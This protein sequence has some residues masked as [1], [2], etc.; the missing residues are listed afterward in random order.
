MTLRWQDFCKSI[1]FICIESA[2]GQVFDFLIELPEVCGIPIAKHPGQNSSNFI[3]LISPYTSGFGGLAHAS[4]I[5]RYTKDGQGS[6]T[7]VNILKDAL[8][9]EYRVSHITFSS[10]IFSLVRPLPSTKIWLHSLYLY[11]RFPV[12]HRFLLF[13]QIY[14]C[15]MLALCSPF[16]HC[17]YYIMILP[18]VNTLK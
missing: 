1:S 14:S 6:N 12:L 3:C 8:L 7:L 2:T 5:Q 16:H 11:R 18:I 10:S 17:Q 9:N 13:F 4:I 15:Y